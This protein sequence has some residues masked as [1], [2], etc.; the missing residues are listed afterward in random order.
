MRHV[1][2]EKNA[3]YF[4][5]IYTWWI[6]ISAHLAPGWT[7][8]QVDFAV[9]YSVQNCSV[10]SLLCL[11]KNVA[12][13]AIKI[14]N[15]MKAVLQ[16]HQPTKANSWG[17]KLCVKHDMTQDMSFLSCDSVT[18]SSL[19]LTKYCQESTGWNIYHP[20][21]IYHGRNICELGQIHTREL[22]YFRLGRAE[23]VFQS[24][25]L[26]QVYQRYTANMSA[27]TARAKKPISPQRSAFLLRGEH[28]D[29]P[30]RPGEGNQRLFPL[31]ETNQATQITGKSQKKVFSAW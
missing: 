23:K 9:K 2:T 3:N 17:S 22:I 14:C 11:T 19:H 24:W 10:N 30:S 1:C 25:G 6:A 27:S 21:I 16:N 13:F 18:N 20:L 12:W 8:L 5:Y 15:T 26:C 4:I 31:A 7:G 29:L 28:S